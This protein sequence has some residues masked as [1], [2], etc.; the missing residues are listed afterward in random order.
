[1]LLEVWL[2]SATLQQ[3]KMWRLCVQELRMKHPRITRGAIP[4][5]RKPIIYGLCSN[6]A[7]TY[8]RGT[9][10]PWSQPLAAFMLGFVFAMM[11]A[12][13]RMVERG[14]ASFRWCAMNWSASANM[15]V[16]T[17]YNFVMR[18]LTFPTP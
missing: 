18:L 9:P 16:P 8:S 1:M 15:S 14:G 6:K 3:L 7:S 10:R 11:S 12:L 5:M 4:K 13:C 17:E 2:L